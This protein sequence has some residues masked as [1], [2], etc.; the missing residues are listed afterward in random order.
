MIYKSVL[1]VSA[2]LNFTTFH[3]RYFD[4]IEKMYLNS[5]FLIQAVQELLL[6]T[7]GKKRKQE[8]VTNLCLAPTSLEEYNR[9][10]HYSLKNKYMLSKGQ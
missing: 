4:L 6:D 7:E 1:H 2:N 9:T 8:W 3:I 5:V 10:L